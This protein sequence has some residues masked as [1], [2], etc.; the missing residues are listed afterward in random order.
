[1][2]IRFA[3][4]SVSPP[5]SDIFARA[6]EAG[7]DG[8]EVAASDD[9]VRTREL[10]QA[11]GIEIACLVSNFEIPAKA[12]ARG[13]VTSEV[14]RL[15][16]AAAAMGCPNLRVRVG[17]LGRGQGVGAFAGEVKEWLV[18][19]ADRA[20][21]R[22]V[23]ILIENTPPFARSRDLWTLLDLVD[24]PH[25]G[26]AWDLANAGRV[27]ERPYVAVPTLN[28]RIRYVVVGEGEA[29]VHNLLDRLRGIGYGGYVAVRS[30]EEGMAAGLAGL[31]AGE[32][33]GA[34]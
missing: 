5:T 11:A 28:S 31:R 6:R 27:G 21:E 32:A 20:G 12:G 14:E 30:S 16:E 7:Y 4:S 3:F 34:K 13:K 18:P 17:V 33:V 19:L 2:P 10:A 1:M 23:T 24:R 29:G 26:A 22:G 9:P 25:V 8:V 15:I